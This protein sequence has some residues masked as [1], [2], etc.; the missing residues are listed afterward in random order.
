MWDTIWTNADLATMAGGAPYGAI[1]DGAI[2]AADGRIAWVGPHAALPDA[3]ERLARTVR[4]AGSRWIT[5]G[6][7]DCHTHAIF[8]GNR[9]L[10]FEMALGGAGRQEIIAAG[11]GI[12]STVRNTRAAGEDELFVGARRRLKLLMAEG[13]TTV[14]IKSGYGLDIDTEAKQ[15]RV[16]RELGRRL[17]VTVRTTFLGAHQVAPEYAGRADDYIDWVARVSLPAAARQGLVDMVDGTLE[18]GHFTPPQIERLFAAAHALGLPV[19]AHT[20]Q[21]SDGGGGAVVARNGG[22]SADHL[23]Y[24]S[25]ESVAAMAASGTVAVMLPGANYTV[26]EKRVPPIAWFR[27][28]GVPMA[29]ATNCNPGTSPATSILM[30]LNMAA[31]LFRMTPEEALAGVT[32]NA[33]RALGLVADCGTLEV[34]KAADLV[35]WDIERPGELAYRIGW[36]PCHQVIKAGAV[37][38]TAAAI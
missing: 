7:I 5:P 15:L 35:L 11:G 36:N 37:V 24:V 27:E 2:A 31:T 10:D 4:D 6:L 16:A 38:H 20:D 12:Q 1:P 23:E 32:R 22:L 9:I 8:A 21:Y 26:R 14:E 28:A 34:G 17:P 33:A 18:P 3:P 29:V 30:M 13:V 19:K 25:R